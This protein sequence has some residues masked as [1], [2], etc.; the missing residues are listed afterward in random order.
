MWSWRARGV[1]DEIR[2]C[3]KG[4]PEAESRSRCAVKYDDG[5]SD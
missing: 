2:E 5:N 4:N 1:R 3:V